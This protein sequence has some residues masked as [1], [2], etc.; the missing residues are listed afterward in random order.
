MKGALA[1]RA[2]FENTLR[3]PSCRFAV[4]SLACQ[5]LRELGVQLPHCC[6]IYCDNKSAAAIAHTPVGHKYTKHIDIRLMFLKELCCD[7]KIFDIVFTGSKTNLSNSNTK[8]TANREFLSFREYF[9]GFARE[10]PALLDRVVQR[11]SQMD[12]VKKRTPPT[13]SSPA[14]VLYTYQYKL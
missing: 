4:R 9:K 2:R 11:F 1:Q 3:I 6:E 5:L 7:R 10:H 13:P 14:A 12:F 8:T